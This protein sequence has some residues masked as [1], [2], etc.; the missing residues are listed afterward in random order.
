MNGDDND[1]GE[2]TFRFCTSYPSRG[3]YAASSDEAEEAAA[4]YNYHRD[5]PVAAHRRHVLFRPLH[6]YDY[7]DDC[8][9]DVRD[10]YDAD[11]E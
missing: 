4:D 1:G 6:Y 9:Y 11:D 3:E 8:D 5:D 10:D 2:R 7:D